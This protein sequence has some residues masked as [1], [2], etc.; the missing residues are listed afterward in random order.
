MTCL[1]PA[2]PS[3]SRWI[4]RF[5][6]AAAMMFAPSLALAEETPVTDQTVWSHWDLTPIIVIP[7]VLVLAVYAAGLIRRPGSFEAA[8]WRHAA[9]F[10]GMVFTVM[11]L[12]SPIDAFAD[13]LFWMHQIQHMLIRV[14]GPMLIAL[15]QPQ[16]TLIAGLPLWLKRK[17]LTPIVGAGPIQAVFAGLTQPLAVTVLFIVSLYAWQ[18]PPVHNLAIVNEDVHDTM[19]F[20]MLAAGLLFFW[21]VFDHRP[22]PK[23]TRYGVRLMMLWAAV[24]S[25]IPIGA[26]TAFKTRELYPAY[27]IE[28]RLFHW[29]AMA[30][31]RLGGFIMWAPSS[32]MMLLAILLVVHAWGREEERQDARV[33]PTAPVMA[34]AMLAQQR[35][36]NN[37]LALGLVAF[38]AWRAGRDG[39]D[40]PAGRAPAPTRCARTCRHGLRRLWD[41]APRPALR[42]AAPNRGHVC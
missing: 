25:N 7:T 24:L 23:G 34:E 40:R 26:Y 9:F 12:V 28:G 22:A 2:R 14:I 41:R 32:M 35:P 21:R 6:L 5:A 4:R 19:H 29:S 1:S 38:V 30:D 36:K 39:V 3:P 42:S 18:W 8:P 11:S 15:S 17:G 16:S 31:E 27:D 20:T 10:W 33:A 13:R 37:A